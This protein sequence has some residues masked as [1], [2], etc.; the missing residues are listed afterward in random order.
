M[1]QDWKAKQIEAE[2]KILRKLFDKWSDSIKEETGR[3]GTQ[4]LFAFMLNHPKGEKPF[5]SKNPK[6]RKMSEECWSNN[7]DC[8]EALRKH[9]FKCEPHNINQVGKWLKGKELISSEYK[10][11]ICK[12]C[13]V[14]ENYFD[15]DSWGIISWSYNISA[16][17]KRVEELRQYSKNIGLSEDFV[18]YITDLPDIAKIFPFH[19]DTLPDITESRS[20][21][22]YEITD[23]FGK[24]AFLNEED[25]DYLKLLQTEIMTTSIEEIIRLKLSVEKQHIQDEKER[26]FLRNR[27]RSHSEEEHFDETIEKMFISRGISEKSDI[28]MSCLNSFYS[29]LDPEKEYLI[30]EASIRTRRETENG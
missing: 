21:T 23:S 29:L 18:R 7:A 9:N 20:E 1:S 10:R 4:G 30:E 3:K 28:T 17:N 16:R 27:L 5:K 11:Q 26:L 14:K 13:G 2:S 6:E 22:A 12:V 8:W 19:F 24:T 15:P 25:L